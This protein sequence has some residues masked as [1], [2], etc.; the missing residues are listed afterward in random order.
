MVIIHTGHQADF[1]AKVIKA[2]KRYDTDIIKV[3][4]ITDLVQAFQ[5]E[6]FDI[7]LVSLDGIATPF[8]I[9]KEQMS[10]QLEST[11]IIGLGKIPSEIVQ[12]IDICIFPEF[13][14]NKDILESII[15]GIIRLARK[16][17]NRSELSAM[18]LHDLR[19]PLQS[20]IGYLELLQNDIFGE[21]NEGQHQIL[22]NAL[23]LGDVTVNLL[24]E[25]SQVFQYESKDF[26]VQKSHIK[27]KDTMDDVLR[28]L[29][30]QADKKN[31]KFVPQVAAQLPDL[32][33]DKLAIQRVLINLLTNA[34]NFSPENGLVRIEVLSASSLTPKQHVLFQIMDSG[35]GIPAEQIDLI[36]DKYNRL[37]NK[38]AGRKKGFGLGLYVSKL[39]VE[40]HDG[41]IGIHNNRE[42][43]STFYFTLPAYRNE[44]DASA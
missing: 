18:L 8:Q 19:S 17:K 34:I 6:S 33:A 1:T 42:G 12:E 40:A 13:I 32:Y 22:S 16:E 39:I 41:Q 44:T 26:S 15:D 35:P 28:A 7:L 43:G 9:I 27:I 25:L 10:G 21:M 29:W 37:R 36:F 3:K 30:I 31:I 38:K 20:I 11:L 23:S 24:E 4:S 5:E 14:E 2:L